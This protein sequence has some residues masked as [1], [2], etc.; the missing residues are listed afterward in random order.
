V[1]REHGRTIP[2]TDLS[3]SPLYASDEQKKLANGLKIG[4]MGLMSG[5]AIATPAPD[6]NPLLDLQE[7]RD[8]FALTMGVGLGKDGF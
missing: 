2:L 6:S 5:N 7:Q 8:K 1:G 3:P 4:P